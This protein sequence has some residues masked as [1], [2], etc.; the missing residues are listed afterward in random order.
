MILE[1]V[2]SGRQRSPC[3]FYRQCT[4]AGHE[5]LAVVTQPDRPRQKK[6]L[7]PP[8]AKSVRRRWGFPYCSLKESNGG[9]CTSI[10]VFGRRRLVTAAYGQILSRL[11]DL[12]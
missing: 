8:E 10:G 6:V 9:G 12:P 3:L 5:I 4:S 7:T 11:L 2:F 1:L